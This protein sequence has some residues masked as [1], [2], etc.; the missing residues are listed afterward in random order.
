MKTIELGEAT[1]PLSDYARR[2]RTEPLVVTLRGRP[3]VA[4]MSVGDVDGEELRLSLDPKFMAIIEKSRASHKPGTGISTDAM[5]RRLGLK[6][7]AG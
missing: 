7:K 1:D 5:R 4:L 3:F 6:R 2:A